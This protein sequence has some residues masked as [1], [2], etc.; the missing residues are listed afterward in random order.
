MNYHNGGVCVFPQEHDNETRTL[1]GVKYYYDTYPEDGIPVPEGF[2]YLRTDNGIDVYQNDSFLGMGFSYDTYLPRSEFDNIVETG[3]NCA[4]VMLHTLVVEDEDVALVKDILK[5][6]QEGYRCQEREFFDKFTMTSDGFSAKIKLNQPEVMF[7]SVP[8]EDQG[9]IAECNGEELSFIRANIG[10][11]AFRLP[12]GE[13]E[14]NFRY[15]SPVDR[16]GRY[17]T[18]AGWIVMLIYVMIQEKKRM[19]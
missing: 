13:N 12:A 14:L 6:H 19:N 7:V 18:C 15:Q 8:Y 3:E 2:S 4:E 1:L 11:L 5:P 9:W 10:L 17:V 16:I